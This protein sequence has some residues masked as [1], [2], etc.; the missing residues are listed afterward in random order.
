MHRCSNTIGALAGAL[1][2]AQAEL[3][4]P[5]KSM[6]ATIAAAF[7]R[8]A[9]R[10][11][12]YASLSS[13]LDIVR[14]C[15]G[16]HEIATVQTT[17]IDSEAGL[18]RLT[19]VLAHSSG[20]WMSSDWPVCPVSETGAPHRM[21]AALT[22]A[23]RYALFTLVGI[24]GEDD[25]DAPDLPVLQ[26]QGGGAAANGGAK[27]PGQ[28][29]GQAGLPSWHSPGGPLTDRTRRK[30]GAAPAK[31]VLGADASAAVRDQL[32]AEIA[33]LA[34]TDQIDG[35]AVGGLPTK[36]T[37]TAAD[38]VL[39]EAAFREKLTE[40]PGLQQP[41]S[42]A[43]KAEALAPAQDLVL[44]TDAIVQAAPAAGAPSKLDFE[45][46]AV[47]P[48]QRRLRDK[49]HRQFVAAQPCAVC[50]RQPSDAHHLRFAQ[51]RGLG[52]KVSDEFTVPLC[53]AHHS[54]LHRA[55]KEMEWWKQFGVN[56]MGI[57]YKLWTTSHPIPEAAH[58]AP[59]TEIFA[60]TTGAGA[61]PSLAEG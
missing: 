49:R 18:I 47:I 35:W 8:E 7:P 13:G 44:P 50:G 28:S 10:T 25:L 37:L 9:D 41:M 3:T 45:H 19:T 22:Y 5:E 53:R 36:N 14:K 2:K 15:L 31:P 34:A 30:V 1:A 11:F 43:Q 55:G 42:D 57:A 38:A 32:L 33:D 26:I 51:P 23:R 16:Q 60:A 4:N 27:T 21:G 59:T 6:T 12:R 46:Y 58:P 20:E 29:N 56:S 54:E 24:A 39:V 40:L 61:K 52:T 17:A 48:K